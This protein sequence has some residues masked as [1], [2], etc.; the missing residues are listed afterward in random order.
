MKGTYIPS[1]RWNVMPIIYLTT[2]GAKTGLSRSNPVL[3]IPDGENLILVGSNW[4]KPLNPK[5][6][7]NL[8]VHPKAHIRTGKEELEYSVRELDG[9]ARKKYWQKAVAFYPPYVSYEQRSKRRLPIFILKPIH[10]EN[11]E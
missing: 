11:V 2:I 8:R 3:S 7:Y 4:G 5:W 1:A 6:V 9:E 10:K